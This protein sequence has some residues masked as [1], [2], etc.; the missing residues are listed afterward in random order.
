MDTRGEHFQVSIAYNRRRGVAAHGTG[1]FLTW[2]PNCVAWCRA[3]RGLEAWQRKM[4]W[5]AGFT[6]WQ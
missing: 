3:V 6:F 4:T 2:E 5:K 1:I